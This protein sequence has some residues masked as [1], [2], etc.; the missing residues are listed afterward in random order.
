MA[1]EYISD[2]TEGNFTIGGVTSGDGFFYL[3]CNDSTL[4]QYNYSTLA[5]SASGTSGFTSSGVALLTIAT[6]A[7]ATVI[8]CSN[9]TARY[10]VY[11]F[12]QGT[13][14]GI[15]SNAVTTK[16]L[17]NNQQIASNP[18]LG[19]CIIT[20]AASGGVRLV[21]TTTATLVSIP[22]MTNEAA[23]CVLSRTPSSTWILGGD[24][25]TVREI[26]SAGAVLQSV[27][28]PATTSA[29]GNQFQAVV[30]LAA[31]DK[32]VVAA[33]DRGTIFCIDWDAGAVV[34]RMMCAH[35]TNNLSLSNSVSG[36][37][38]LPSGN[39]PTSNY[40]LTEVYFGSGKF[41][42]QD[43]FVEES[44][45]STFGASIDIATNRAVRVSSSSAFKARMFNITPANRV[46]VDTRIQYP[47]GTDI[48]GT[49][50]RF[51][52]AGIGKA[53]IESITSIG[54]SVT[55]IPATEDVGYIEVAL[56]SSPSGGWD[57]REF[58]S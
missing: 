55:S 25:G 23:N 48:P 5:L 21:T 13:R 41:S 31:Y 4:R 6:G 7:S 45:I 32:Y 42:I 37:F 40:T 34:D 20:Q 30:G 17:N 44:G 18:A 57:V 49:I 54:A 52:D 43:V 10:D 15:T 36:T 22:G 33:T 46:G 9:N 1:L 8:A 35:G 27:P 56:T 47:L 38:L 26:N 58:K 39:A 28:L 24:L 51:R 29:S 50:V 53:I 2:L 16:L 3:G 14:T 11:V 12:P 19:T